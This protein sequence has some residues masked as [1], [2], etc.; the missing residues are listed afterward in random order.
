MM[1][2]TMSTI[3]AVTDLTLASYGLVGLA[4]MVAK[5]SRAEVV[6][7]SMH[8]GRDRS[9]RQDRSRRRSS[10]PPPQALRHEGQLLEKQRQ[11][12]A[13]HGV[14]C[15][16]ELLDDSSWAELVIRSAQRV[17][18]DL[19]LLG[20]QLL[21]EDGRAIPEEMQSLAADAPCPVTLVRVPRPW[22]FRSD[23]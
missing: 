11:W 22:T 21:G 9:E 14:R 7:V 20:A 1:R 6:L 19:I 18:A 23:S 13:D 17:G 16:A 4:A 12:C 2:E 5:P 3:L 15:K 8:R 10:H